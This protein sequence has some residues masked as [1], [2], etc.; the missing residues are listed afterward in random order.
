MEAHRRFPWMLFVAALVAVCLVQLPL[1]LNP[2]YFSHDE[3]QWGYYATQITGGFFG[4][5]LWTDVR[6]FQYRPLTFSLWIALSRR[7]FE[8][9][10]AFHAVIVGWGAV[11]AGMLAAL[12]RRHGAHVWLAWAGALIFA[13]S[14][15]T[16]YTHGWVATIGDLVW[17]SSGLLIALLVDR[18]PA[19]PLLALGAFVL[20]GAALLAK[21]SA[22]VIPALAAL[23]WWFSGRQRGWSVAVLASAAPVAIYLAL[24]LKTI[25]FSTETAGTIY[26]WSLLS[27]PMRWLEYQLFPTLTSRLGAG[28]FIQK[29]L[30]SR[31]ILIALMGWLLLAWALWRTGARWL[32]AFLSGGV[33]ALGPVLLLADAALQYGYG[34]AAVSTGV[35]ILA[36][37]RMPRLSRV[38]VA[39]VA[40]FSLWHGI[41]IM[42]SMH[43]TGVKQAHFSPAMAEVVASASAPVRLRPEVEKDRWIYVRLTHEI[44]S[45]RGVAIGDRVSLVAQEAPADYVIRADGR[46]QALR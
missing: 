27:I 18:Q 29:G 6:A 45:Y 9:P 11:N 40:F 10:Y 3:L 42:R 34:F 7:L 13:L 8:H 36:W 2:G 38:V 4:N 30:G 25:L 12:L 21:E 15:Y 46:L 20:T 5:G 19:V 33:V 37:H 1:V 23:A 26:H 28:D 32:L 41:N 17:V 24:R 39:T 44:P 16:A 35:C 43:D 31:Q 22:I 14:P